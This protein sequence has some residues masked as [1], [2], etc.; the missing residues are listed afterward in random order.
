MPTSALEDEVERIWAE[1]PGIGAGALMKL[2]KNRDGEDR[3]PNL[4]K[5]SVKLAIQAIPYVFQKDISVDDNPVDQNFVTEKLE[6]RSSHRS[7]RQFQAADHIERG[8]TAMGVVIDDWKRTWKIG[9]RPQTNQVVKETKSDI[10]NGVQCDLCGRLFGSRNLVFAHLRDPASGCG[11]EIFSTGMSL[12]AP[13]SVARR[14]EKKSTRTRTRKTGKTSLHAHANQCLWIGDL[15][16]PWTRMGGQHRYL[17]SM[18][19]ELLPSDVPQ[20]WLKKVV[21]K[22][23]KKNGRY[24]GYAVVV[25]R[26]AQEADAIA[27]RWND[28]KVSTLLIFGK[29]FFENEKIAV[30]HQ[31]PPFTMKVRPVKNSDIHD[32]TEVDR[33]C[34]N[35]QTRIPGQDPPLYLQ[36]QPLGEDELRL[37][38]RRLQTRMS[39]ED[40]TDTVEEEDVSGGRTLP[41]VVASCYDKL[42]DQGINIRPKVSHTGEPVP[43]ELLHP[44][45][46]I[47]S[48]LRWPAQNQRQGLSAERYLVLATNAEQSDLYYADLRQA[49][50]SLMDWVDPGYYYSAIAVTKNFV[51]SPHI[52]DRDQSFQY[53]VALGDDYKGGELCVEGIGKEGWDFVNVVDTK[54]RVA[55]VDGRHVHWVRT[56][57]GG[58]RYS[59]IFYDTS[60]R[61]PSAVNPIGVIDYQR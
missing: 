42:Q 23:Y 24:L 6:Q 32:S 55:K 27:E 50:R 61:K 47:L 54:N 3:Y 12:A 44:I 25:F 37:R 45:R 11:T 51:A 21:R 30:L 39:E 9:R 57:S 29:N 26:D 35:K 46:E 2:L 22:A 16:L 10:P 20:P 36:L 5:K 19:R 8:L 58:D 18:I 52:D 56:W 17:R 4:T 1:Q 60:D 15:P 33:D 43:P 7:A 13:P 38:L 31:E 49:C 41:K 34:T 40:Q 53:A 14:L 48:T 59:L 28:R